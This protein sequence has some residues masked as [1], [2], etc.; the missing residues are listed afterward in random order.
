M[1]SNAARRSIL[2]WTSWRRAGRFAD[3]R[4][5]VLAES[6]SSEETAGE[7]RIGLFYYRLS[8]LSCSIFLPGGN[9]E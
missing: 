4:G 7:R 8:P 5:V 2:R 9:R 1:I 6:E 3:H